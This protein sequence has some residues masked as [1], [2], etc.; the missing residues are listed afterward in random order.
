MG[1]ANAQNINFTGVWQVDLDASDSVDAILKAQGKSRLER[2]VAKTMKVIQ[3]INQ[4]SEQMSVHIKSMAMDST[5]NFPLNKQWI[6]ID[7]PKMGRVQARNYWI[8]GHQ[9][10]VTEM[11]ITV[12]N[13]P[14]TMKITR[15]LLNAGN[16]MQLY[17]ELILNN[18]EVYSAVRVFRRQ[19]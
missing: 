16:T 2:R 8:N 18:G 14:A 13:Q 15:R 17:L 4:S 19:S 3:S 1:L 6:W 5:Q 9:A 7:T 11:Q 10:I 12:R